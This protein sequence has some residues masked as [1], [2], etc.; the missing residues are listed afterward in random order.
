MQDSFKCCDKHEL[1]IIAYNTPLL[2]N[3]N[4]G[5]D[6]NNSSHCEIPD[7][8]EVDRTGYLAAVLVY[9]NNSVEARIP[10]SRKGMSLP[11]LT[12]AFKTSLPVSCSVICTILEKPG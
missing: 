1:E 11:E 9:E 8:S 4:I 6:L 2:S 12:V 5:K 7:I 10:L 3:P